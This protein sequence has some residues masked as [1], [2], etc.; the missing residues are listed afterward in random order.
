M[1]DLTAAQAKQRLGA[2]RAEMR[3]ARLDA[4]L[5]L[6]AA[7]IR[8]LTGFAGEGA[9]VL[10]ASRSAWVLVAWRNVQR[11]TQQTAGCAVVSLKER[12]RFL[13]N[14]VR[15]RGRCAIGIEG[16]GSYRAFIGRRKALKPGRLTETQI[17]R[18]CRALKSPAEIALIRAA[19]RDTERVFDQFLGEIRP[20]L[21]ERQLN[22]RLVQIILDNAK[23]DGPSFEPIVAS[24]TSAWA[25]HS[26]FTDRKIRRNDCIILDLGVRYRGYCADMTRT[27]FVGKPT[28][29]MREIYAIVLEAQQ[30]AIAATRA[31]VPGT[32]VEA[33]ARDLIR[34]H[35]FGDHFAHG[36][37]HGIGLEVHEPP[38]LGGKAPLREGMV[39]TIEPGIYIQDQ[40]GVRIED[41]VLVT[42]DGCENLTRT[43]K[44][45]TVVG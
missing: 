41:M 28:R 10:V 44:E 23:V 33:A 20:G 13:R 5:V 18:E 14:W 45:L 6:D 4:L 37:G 34:E 42:A 40:F 1:A 31:G 43:P 17:V 38:G 12:P 21:T 39:V 26:R 15:R 24:G 32:E 8:Y 35:G 22:H 19:Q 25:P 11:A 27:V 36:L 29:R 9:Q 2:V 16:A 7:S 30:R 3:K